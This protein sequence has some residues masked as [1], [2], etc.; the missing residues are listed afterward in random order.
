MFKWLLLFSICMVTSA[1]AQKKS[2]KVIAYY[3][4]PADSL[5]NYQLEKVTHLIYCFLHLRNDTLGEGSIVQQENLKKVSA[6]KKQYPHLN[7]LISL[8]GWGGCYTCS[9]IFSTHKGRSTFALTT[10]QLLDKYNLDGIDLDW[11]YPAIEGYPGHPFSPADKE[12]FTFLITELRLALGPKKIISFAAGGFTHYVEHAIDWQSVMP[13]V[14]FVN[15]MTYDL[16][17][18]YS[19][20]TG[21]HTLLY[22]YKENQ[23]ST[24]RCVG[25]LLQHKVDA[26]KLIIGAAFYARVWGKVAPT[27]NGLYQSGTFTAGVPYKKFDTFFA[28][29]TGFKKHWDRKA[30]AHYFYNSQRQLFGTGDTK[31]SI[32]RKCNYVT[33]HHLGGLMFWQLGD[34]KKR[35]GLLA[36]ITHKLRKK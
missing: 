35:N 14:D 36:V 33:K 11:E 13:Q 21:H 23:Q 10:A 32:K 28:N 6:L 17:S 7:V 19:T 5:A 34:D 30:K 4:G 24:A 29:S 20:V 22:D 12:N 16:V 31:R 26:D 1:A 25:W 2:Y 15:L 18:G 8:G 9:P 3:A 27:A